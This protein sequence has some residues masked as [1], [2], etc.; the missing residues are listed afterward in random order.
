MIIAEHNNAFCDVELYG[1]EQIL[2]EQLINIIKALAIKLNKDEITILQTLEY[3]FF[4]EEE[5]KK[6]ITIKKLFEKFNKECK[7]HKNLHPLQESEL[8]LYNKKECVLHK[9][10]TKKYKKKNSNKIKETLL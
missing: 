8:Y 3:Y 7:K 6:Q 9:Q 1:D 4:L 10:D 5:N 2:M